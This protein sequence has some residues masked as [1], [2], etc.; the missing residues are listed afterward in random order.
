MTVIN[1]IIIVITISIVM[2]VAIIVIILIIH[3]HYHYLRLV[4][5]ISSSLTTTSSKRWAVSS[6]KGIKVSISLL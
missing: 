5:T 4:Q 1:D 3:P 6:T 2:I